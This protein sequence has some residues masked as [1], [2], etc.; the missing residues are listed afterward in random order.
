MS[1]ERMMIL[2]ML[3]EGKISADEAARLLDALAEQPRATPSGSGIA[4]DIRRA[5]EDI[6]RAIPKESIDEARDVI[7]ETVREGVE[8]ARE[9]ARVARDAGRWGGKWGK[10]GWHLHTTIGGHHATA[11]FEDVRATHASHLTFRNTRGDLRLS[12]SPDSQLHVRATRR[13]WGSD[14]GEAQRLADRLP[15]EIT[16][17]GDTITVEGP[18]ARPYHERLRV[19]FEIAVPDTL[20]VGGHLVRGDVTAEALT[21][22]LALTVVKGDVRAA[23]CARVEVQGVSSAV[24][25]DR[26]RG[27][28]AVRVIRGDV[29]VRQASGNIAVSTKRGDV[30]IRVETAGQLAA[31]VVRG[32][33]RLRAREFASGGGAAA[34]AVRGDIAVSLGPTAQ[35]RIEAATVSGEISSTLPLVGLRGDRRALSGVFNNADAGVHL[36]TTRGDITLT[37]LEGAAVE[38]QAAPA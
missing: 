14:P 27:D 26:S 34:Q 18:G 15:I 25:L 12:R 17:S 19:D 38:S 22:D 5:V 37:V 31:S 9:S 6:T 3:Q 35:C 1:E 33:I 23:D 29:A 13:V 4:D 36:R 11:P 20:D 7:R 10:W 28:A 21:R 30:D 2:R 8:F 24:I 32:D 16:E